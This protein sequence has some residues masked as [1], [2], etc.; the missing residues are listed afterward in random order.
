MKIPAIFAHPPTIAS[1]ATALQLFLGGPPLPML[2]CST[3]WR[4]AQPSHCLV[5]AGVS[6]LQPEHFTISFTEVFTASVHS[7]ASAPGL[8]LA[9]M[10]N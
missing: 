6:V 8:A 7:R 3:G 10:R 1:L 9:K 5:S 4:L 2:V